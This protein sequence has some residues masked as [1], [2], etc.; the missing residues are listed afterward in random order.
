MVLSPNYSILTFLLSSEIDIH[1]KL[2]ISI[3]ASAK[4]TWDELQKYLDVYMLHLQNAYRKCQ[5]RLRPRK[6]NNIDVMSSN[7]MYQIIQ[8]ILLPWVLVKLSWF[9]VGANID[10]L[11]GYNVCSDNS[12]TKSFYHYKNIK[13][14]HDKFKTHNF[15]KGKNIM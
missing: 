2:F 7:F 13:T 8:W 6:K 10:L 11:V 1:Y 12:D 15:M 4:R 3:F 9:S 14:A 5:G